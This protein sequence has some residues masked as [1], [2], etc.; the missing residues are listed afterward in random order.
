M[1]LGGTAWL[2]AALVVFGTATSAA[3]A[4]H[5]VDYE[6]DGLGIYSV[7]RASIEFPMIY[8]TDP[9][10]DQKLMRW[11]CQYFRSDLEL[12]FK[13]KLRN[14]IDVHGTL[15]PATDL[16]GRSTFDHY[17]TVVRSGYL[18]HI[19]KVHGLEAF[20]RVESENSRVKV[21]FHLSKERGISISNCN[22]LG[23][24]PHCYMVVDHPGGATR[25]S[26]FFDARLLPKWQEIAR[27]IEAEVSSWRGQSL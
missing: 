13:T 9:Q 4:C 10:F 11:Q 17:D 1:S 24:H 3:A 7:P 19:G 8:E 12:R 26:I 23:K 15:R 14:G 18:T 27:L 22:H 2:A 5:R 21:Y 16:I 25:T 6:I 20:D